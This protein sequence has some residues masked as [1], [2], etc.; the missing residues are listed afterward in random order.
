MDLGSINK[1]SDSK[2]NASSFNSKV[3][4]KHKTLENVKMYQNYLESPTL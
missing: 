4:I 1:Q 2:Y 3:A